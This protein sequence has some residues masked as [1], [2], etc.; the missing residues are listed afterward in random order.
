M[1][2]S[3]IS[4]LCIRLETLLCV[5]TPVFDLLHLLSAGR[6]FGLVTD[7]L[8]DLGRDLDWDLATVLL[9][10]LDTPLLRDLLTHLPWN[11]VT[12]FL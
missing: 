2:K 1:M 8:G 7:S 10:Y 5:L 12:D 3:N 6:I 11:L 9:G 4:T